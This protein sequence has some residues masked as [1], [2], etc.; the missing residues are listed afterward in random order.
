M[1]EGKLQADGT[2]RWGRSG[3][4]DVMPSMYGSYVTGYTPYCMKDEETPSV[5]WRI[6]YADEENVYLIAD[7]YILN[8][9]TPSAPDGKRLSSVSYNGRS[10]YCASFN[11]IL[12]SYNGSSDITHNNP[13][14]KWLSAYYENEYIRNNDNMKKTAYMMDTVQWNDYYKDAN[15]SSMVEYAIGGPTLELF[16]ASY[17][18]TY[19][20]KTIDVSTKYTL[21]N[22]NTGYVIKWSTDTDYTWERFYLNINDTLYAFS[23]AET[24]WRMWLAS[25]SAMYKDRLLDVTTNCGIDSTGYGAESYSGGGFRPIV[26]LSSSV[27]LIDNGDGTYRVN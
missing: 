11:K 20:N 4:E 10:R 15:N 2:I 1:A 24:S 27:K 19:S 23:D 26:C 21:Q 9:Y 13:A 18:Q 6:F 5:G 22:D 7:K 3:A 25:P 16:I 8:K 17:N 14:Y 12:N